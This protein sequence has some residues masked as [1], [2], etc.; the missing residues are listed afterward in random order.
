MGYMGRDKKKQATGQVLPTEVPDESAHDHCQGQTDFDNRVALLIA[1]PPKP[2][3]VFHSPDR[4]VPTLNLLG[5][6][7][8]LVSFCWS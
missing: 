2:G 3:S 7:A 8:A 4:D 5:S 1:G 6:A